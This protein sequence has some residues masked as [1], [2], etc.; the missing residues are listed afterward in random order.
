MLREKS[1]D[2]LFQLG[3][4]NCKLLGRYHIVS[5]VVVSHFSCFFSPNNI[6]GGLLYYSELC[7]FK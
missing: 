3:I 2:F 6:I 7:T 4:R 1:D 5:D